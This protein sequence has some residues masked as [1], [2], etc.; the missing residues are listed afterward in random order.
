MISYDDEFKI[1]LS[2]CCKAIPTGE[3]MILDMETYAIGICSK[4][5]AHTGFMME[6]FNEQAEN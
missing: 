1:Y 6:E 3:V 5:D 4:C 2:D